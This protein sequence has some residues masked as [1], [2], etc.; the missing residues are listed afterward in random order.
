MMNEMCKQ[1]LHQIYDLCPFKWHSTSE[2][3]LLN[4]YTCYGP[5][6]K[7][8]CYLHVIPRLS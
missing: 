6:Y 3:C 5:S 8:L 2:Q 1:P 4:L 7:S